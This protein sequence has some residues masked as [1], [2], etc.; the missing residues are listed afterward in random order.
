MFSEVASFI[1]GLAVGVTCTVLVDIFR[2]CISPSPR[3]TTSPSVPHYNDL[4]PTL[5]ILQQPHHDSP[6]TGFLQSSKFKTFPLPQK[7][8]HLPPNH[9]PMGDRPH[10]P[11]QTA[12]H[13]T[14][15]L[16]HSLKHNHKLLP[17]YTWGQPPPL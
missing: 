9:R 12:Q 2:H 15:Q 13:P 14:P 16:I 11:P 4:F 10:D 7:R 3:P 8:S 1:L 17:I 5:S 6:T